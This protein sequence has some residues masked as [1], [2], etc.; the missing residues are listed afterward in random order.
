MLVYLSLPTPRRGG[1]L[2]IDV[3]L[4]TACCKLVGQRYVAVSLSDHLNVEDDVDIRGACVCGNVGR[5]FR[6]NVP[7]HEAAHETQRGLE[8]AE[9]PEQG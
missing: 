2:R 4:E 9:R 3:A 6:S 8:A 5:R 1:T 7:R